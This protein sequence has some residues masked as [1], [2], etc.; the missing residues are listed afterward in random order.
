MTVLSCGIFDFSRSFFEA[1]TSLTSQGEICSRL[2]F[3]PATFLF[4]TEL[5]FILLTEFRCCVDL[6][7]ESLLSEM[8]G[9]LLLPF[10]L[11]WPGLTEDRDR[12]TG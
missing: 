11:G 2:E 8:T 1:M 9:I 6:E 7:I 4:P 12:V 5:P 3:E 10:T